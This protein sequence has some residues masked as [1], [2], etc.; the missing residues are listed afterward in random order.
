MRSPQFTI[1]EA[2]P[3]E[4]ED[5]GNLFVA[6]FS[7]LE[8]LPRPSERLKYYQMREFYQTLTQ[9]RALASIPT[10]DIIV[11]KNE[12]A[13]LLGGVVFIGDTEFY[14]SNS[15]AISL[16]YASGFRLLTV[17]RETVDQ[18][19]EEALLFE[20]LRRAKECSMQV[21]THTSQLTGSV[22][23]AMLE[24][25]GF[26]RYPAQDFVQNHLVMHGYIMQF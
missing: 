16:Q 17:S 12:E 9:V 3:S 20:C 4:Y 14:D 13:G 19:I 5:L 18:G 1:R 22:G 23:G 21:L 10:T 7:A 6:T 24:K 2:H 26:Q 15:N 8:N 11:A 25:F